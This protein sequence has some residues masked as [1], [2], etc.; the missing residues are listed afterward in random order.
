MTT[1]PKTRE[2]YKAAILHNIYRLVQALELD[3]DR[4]SPTW[5]AQSIHH[6]TREYFNAERW[7]PRPVNEGIRAK[8]PVGEVLTFRIQKW[9]P[10]AGDPRPGH[11]FV[12]GR[13]VE[14]RDLYYSRDDG[15]NFQ[16]VPTGKRN[17]RE[18]SY[19]VACGQSLKVWRGKLTETEAAAR[20]PLYEHEK[21]PTVQYD[22]EEA[23]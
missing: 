19:R 13:L 7:K 17:P 18:Y 14:I 5:T 4:D 22:K 21:I 11:Q 3:D 12:T 10:E 20:T 15:A 8:L 1:Y 6:D 16:V 2:E 23:A 9:T